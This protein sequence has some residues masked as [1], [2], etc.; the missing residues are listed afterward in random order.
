MQNGICLFLSIV[1]FWCCLVLSCLVF[2]FLF[3]LVSCHL[4]HSNNLFLVSSVCVCPLYVRICLGLGLGL[5]LGVGRGF[6]LGT[7]CLGL[8]LSPASFPSLPSA[9]FLSDKRCGAHT[10]HIRICWRWERRKDPDVVST[11]PVET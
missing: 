1:L 3:L 6:C 9:L 11:I 4:F 10:S 5:G 8:V 7:S 2:M